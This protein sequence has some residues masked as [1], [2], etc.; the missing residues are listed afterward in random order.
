MIQDKFSNKR[1]NSSFKSP[2]KTAYDYL[3]KPQSIC[4]VGASNDDFKPGGRVLKNIKENGYLYELWAVNQNSDNVMGLPTYKSINDLP[5]GPDLALIA[6]PSKFVLQAITDLAAIG[7]KAAIVLTSGFGEIN[8]E[9]KSLELKIRDIA[10]AS[11]LIL[12]G[13]NCSGFLTCCY[14]GKFAGIIPNQGQGLVDVI[15]GSGATVDYVMERGIE[16]GLSFGNV[17]NLGNSVQMGVEDLLKLYNENYNYENARI[18]M[19]YME[20]V[21]KPELLL[22]HAKSLVLKGC[23]VV[24]IKSGTTRD[25]ERAA[26]SHTGAMATSDTAVEALFKKAGII[27][28]PGREWLI[29]V[30]CVLVCLKGPLS[31]KRVCIITDAGGPGV[32][33]SDELNRQ[34]LELPI[35]QKETVRKLSLILPP[36]AAKTNPIDVLPTRTSDQIKL[37]FKCLDESEAGNID[38]IVFLSGNSGLYDNSKIYHEISIA[39]NEC[40]IPIIPVLSSVVTC[41]EKIESYKKDSAAFFTDEV[42]LGAALGKVANWYKPKIHTSKPVNYDKDAIE[43][44]LLEQKGI[45]A[46]EIVSG[47]LKAAG[48]KLPHQIEICSHEK[49]TE[50][51]QKFKFPIVMKVI[52]ALHKTDVNGVKLDIKNFS[53]AESAFGQLMRIPKARGVTIQSMVYGN[54]VILGASHEKGYGHLIMFGIGG[55]YAE[56]IKDVQFALAPLSKEECR[57]LVRGIRCHKIIAGVRGHK[58]LSLEILYDYVLRLSALV[59][60]FPQISEIDM[61]PL[62]GTGIDI[63]AVDA[64]IIV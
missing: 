56:V 16:R 8:E 27:R 20:S 48:F 62:K 21:K 47:I 1:A 11:G 43:K 12:I 57:R 52:G 10:D 38:V 29:D 17:V 46:P 25:G 44:L 18:L 50:N 36:E 15:S 45:L 22:K 5:Y 39:K 7:A 51:L 63:Y 61:N 19:M 60:D 53:E 54:E 35:L 14:K 4:V 24:G 13:P 3:F 41:K 42:N 33:L 49:L 6:I 32:M 2:K 28:V 23:M 59:S 64:R 34:G 55:I 58:G 26:A 31:G 40:Q 30:S 9:G 37:I